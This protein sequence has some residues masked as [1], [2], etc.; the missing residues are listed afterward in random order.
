[1]FTTFAL[2]FLIFLA[3]TTDVAMGTIR[4]ISLYRGKKF[5]AFCLGF[6][7]ILIWIFAVSSVLQNLSEPINIIA[8]ALGFATG[9]YVGVFLE[10]RLIM[11][12][13]LIRIFTA[14]EP[15]EL[16]G[17]IRSKGY[18]LT[19]VEGK[20]AEGPVH[21]LYLIIHR[22]DYPEMARKIQEFNPKAF[23]TTEDVRVAEKGVFPRLRS[24]FRIWK[25]G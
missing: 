22:N 9:N 15:R 7:E 18:G 19:Q 16:M 20:G 8:Y 2:P 3:R 21:I 12:K 5:L 24:P 6:F 1:M 11:G 14:Q 17:Y 13:L 4:T 10:E 25:K 23:Y